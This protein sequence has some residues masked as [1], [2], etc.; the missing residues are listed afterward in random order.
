MSEELLKTIIQL[1][2]IVAKERV[3]EA[4]RNNIQE[5]LS[6][7]LNQEA[8]GYYLKLFDGHNT[9]IQI[10]KQAQLDNID[11]QTLEFVDDWAKIMAISKQ[12]NA[13]LTMQQ[14]AVLIIKIIELVFADGEIS[15]RQENLI[16]YIGEALKISR[17]DM[18]CIKSF[19]LG[20]DLEELSSK[21]ILIIDEG[22]GEYEIKGP[23]IVQ[24][25]LTGLIAILRLGS[26]ETYFIKYLGISVL[27][28][29]GQPL[30]SRKIGVF[31]T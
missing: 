5:F 15:E 4:E 23:R 25:N 18:M 29:N 13:A 8:I 19:V 6:V 12:V 14:K 1:F 26:I 30:K 31:P 2:A 22:S 20:Q 11:D 16:F 3:T 24:K 7:H 21:N 28:L 27:Y 17:R 9:E 10:A